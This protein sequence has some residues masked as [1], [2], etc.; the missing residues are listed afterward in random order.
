MGEVNL[1]QG[2]TVSDTIELLEA[3]GSDAS[4]R[5][6]SAGELSHLLEHTQASA[7]LMAAV[8]SGDSSQ[9]SAEFGQKP[10]QAP[11]VVQSPAHEEEEEGEEPL[12]IPAPEDSHSSPVR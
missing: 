5:H 9:L 6:A 12:D 1:K 7:A 2:K 4:L 11:Q 8:A 10:M 3:I